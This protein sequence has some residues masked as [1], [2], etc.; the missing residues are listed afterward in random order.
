MTSPHFDR[1]RYRYPQRDALARELLDV[2]C[3]PHASVAD[4]LD[5]LAG[6]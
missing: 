2:V 1:H 6:P 3:L 5:F 4:E